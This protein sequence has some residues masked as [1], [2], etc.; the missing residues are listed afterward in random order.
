MN[1]LIDNAGF[2][3]KGAELMLFAVKAKIKNSYPNTKFV[4]RERIA[5]ISLE[6]IKQ[7]GFY[8]LK[9]L[10]SGK[11]K[12]IPDRFTHF[13]GLIRPSNIDLVLDAGGFQFS[14]LWEN[15]YAEKGNTNDVIREYYRKL[16]SKG[17]KIVFL[18]QAFGPFNEKLSRERIEIIHEYADLMY[19][20]DNTSLKYLTDIVGVS[21]KI[22]LASDFTN[23][24]KPSVPLVNLLPQGE[25]IGIIPN[26]KMITHTDS[27]VSNNYF[28]FLLKLC[29]K[30]VENGEK[31]VLLNHE[32]KGDFEIIKKLNSKLPEKVITLTDLNAAE[33]K[34]VISRFKLLVSSR[35]H[36]VV[37]GLSQGIPTFCTGWSHKYEELLNDY[38]VKNNYLPINS[39][40][41]SFAKLS[42][43]LEGKNSNHIQSKE[44]IDKLK[45]NVDNMWTDIIKNY[46]N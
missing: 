23:L 5:S 26:Q 42:S 27:S 20:R 17:A 46:I 39:F 41:E 43:V 11:Y 28:D 21:S 14:D 38:Q 3:N 6:Q 1:V 29:N 35:F 33:V 9:N 10:D 16:K 34:A 44:I 8:V 18:P 36:G 45:E 19:A 12:M 25:Y 4:I 40:S 13:L 2:V 32:G 15:R 30:L 22:K 24:Y 7:E 37:S 31:I